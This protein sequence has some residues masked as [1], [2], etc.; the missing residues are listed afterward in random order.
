[1]INYLSEAGLRQIKHSLDLD[2]L[3]FKFVCFDSE[4]TKWDFW[5][6]ANFRHTCSFLQSL[7]DP[8]S[9]S[10][11]ESKALVIT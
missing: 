6:W 11:V 5:L 9:A 3:N 2:I 7:T 1:M 10:Q 4:T 8:D